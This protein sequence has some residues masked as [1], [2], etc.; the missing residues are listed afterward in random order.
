MRV[1]LLVLSALL[2]MA[3]VLPSLSQAQAVQ[4][5]QVYLLTIAYPLPQVDAHLVVRQGYAQE[6][7][8]NNARDDSAATTGATV[9][10]DCAAL[11]VHNA[12]VAPEVPE[13]PEA[14][15]VPEVPPIP[16]P[17]GEDEPADQD[18]TDDKD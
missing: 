4:D 10:D 14:P 17:D 15:D 13:L 9:L 7:D 2:G 1:N 16:E 6:Q 11:T 5:P 12:A 18:K 8:C 3:L